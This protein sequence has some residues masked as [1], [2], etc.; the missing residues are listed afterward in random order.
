[1]KQTWEGERASSPLP[2]PPE[3]EREKAMPGTVAGTLLNAG[4]KTWESETGLD[5]EP[6]STCSTRGCKGRLE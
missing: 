2:S 6:S 1:M 4:A 3:E 5:R